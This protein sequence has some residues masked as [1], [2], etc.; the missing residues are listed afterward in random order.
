MPP[1]HEQYMNPHGN[2]HPAG[3]EAQCPFL[4]MKKKGEVRKTNE[5]KKNQ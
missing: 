2:G 1:G 4:Q 3:D 5:E